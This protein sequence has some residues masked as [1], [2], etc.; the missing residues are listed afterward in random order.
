[1]V[2]RPHKAE[3]AEKLKNASRMDAFANQMVDLPDAVFVE[4]QNPREQV[5]VAKEGNNW[6]SMNNSDA[7][8]H[9]SVPPGGMKR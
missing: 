3:V 6:S 1:M 2:P 8:V 4:V 7:N 5:H 9:V